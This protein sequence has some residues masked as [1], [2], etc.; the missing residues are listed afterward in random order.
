[1]TPAEFKAGMEL[2]AATFAR[3]LSPALLE[4]YRAQFGGWSGEAW[5]HVVNRACA[6]LR[7]FPKPVE[8]KEMAAV[9]RGDAVERAWGV[10]E[11]ALR[12]VGRYRSVDFGPA[13]NAAVRHVGGWSKLCE[14][15]TDELHFRQRD[16]SKALDL[17][18]RGAVSPELGCHLA[19]LEEG[20]SV[21][22]G[23]L[24]APP[25]DLRGQI[26]GARR[27]LTGPAVR[28]LGPG[29]AA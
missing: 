4:V 21:K 8:L 2:L 17:Y 6:D 18:S 7:F 22:H 1:M 5:M 19:G 16:F 20:D 27:A 24:P 15:S 28:E 23:R 14:T 29:E 26:A 25:V 9:S 10:V 12:T 13:V 11:G 3:D